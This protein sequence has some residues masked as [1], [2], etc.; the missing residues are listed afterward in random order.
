[1]EPS[2][3]YAVTFSFELESLAFVVVFGVAL[4]AAVF[5]PAGVEVTELE[6]KDFVGE[7][8]IVLER[9]NFLFFPPFFP[10]L[11]F[12]FFFFFSFLRL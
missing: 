9:S 8:V 12:F 1:M 11:P 6:P 3:S 4:L 7:I 5:P 2:L 10:F